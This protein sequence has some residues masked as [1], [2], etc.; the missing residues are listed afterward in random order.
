MVLDPIALGASVALALALLA[1]AFAVSTSRA[2]QREAIAR[3]LRPRIAAAAAAAPSPSAVPT[4]RSVVSRGFRP[5]A[6][7]ATPTN[8]AESS[9]L[10]LRLAQAGIRRDNGVQAFLASKVIL[11]VAAVGAFV[12]LNANRAEPIPNALLVGVGL[13]AFGFYAP[14]FWLSTRVEARQTAI[15]RGLPDTLDLLVTCVEAGLGLDAALQRVA[16]EIRRA[17]AILSEEL[18]LTFLEVKAGMK[19]VEAFRRLAERTGIDDLKQLSATL[20][21]TEMF[22]TSIASALRVQAEGMR[23]RR[24]QRAEEKAA[25]VAVKM[26]LPL[27]FNI[28]PSL[29]AVII[30]PAAVNIMEILLPTLK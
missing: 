2:T 23:I 30:G 6:R 24:M 18:E 4:L 3:R 22:G 8:D 29:F 25:M 1:V 26:S 28:L 9:R 21:Q 27:V 13:C 17:H 12:T 15:R 19:R 20:T 11:S 10:R 5:L 7:I 16:G 14:N